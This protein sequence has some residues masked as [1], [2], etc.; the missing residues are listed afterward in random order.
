[1]FGME[2]YLKKASALR[3]LSYTERQKALEALV[4][5]ADYV[6]EVK[7]IKHPFDQGIR[8]RKGIEF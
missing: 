3:S 7:K 2:S 5:E 4:H 1:M 8:A 6:S